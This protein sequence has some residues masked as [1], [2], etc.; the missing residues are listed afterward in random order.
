MRSLIQRALIFAVVLA[1]VFAVA[2]QIPSLPGFPSSSSS[3]GGGGSGGGSGSTNFWYDAGSGNIFAQEAIYN[4]DG[5]VN[6]RL[7]SGVGSN[8][9][10]NQP[11]TA[12][13]ISTSSYPTVGLGFASSGSGA[14]LQGIPYAFNPVDNQYAFAVVNSDT[15]YNAGGLLLWNQSNGGGFGQAP[16]GAAFVTGTA[17]NATYYGKLVA[18]GSSFGYATG[19][20][21]SVQPARNFGFR[22]DSSGTL[23]WTT[24]ANNGE[25]N[26]VGVTAGNDAIQLNNGA[27][28]HLGSGTNDYAF[29]DGTQWTWGGPPLL[30]SYATGSLPAS[31]N[32]S[33]AFDSTVGQPKYYSDGGWQS[34]GGSS[35][36]ANYWYD[37]GAGLITANESISYFASGSGPTDPIAKILL[38]QAGGSVASPSIEWRNQFDGRV[39]ELGRNAHR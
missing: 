8:F 13:A 12:V 24:E 31:S 5:G 23:W 1:S 30:P 3:S 28:L 35:G 17:G 18:G 10:A 4:P 21:V 37:G 25:F 11:A 6:I 29:S 19:I 2:Q 22:N 9:L 20:T 38:R 7:S 33:L 34:F 16:V 15:T 14:Q 39:A 32:G 36:S 27:R 26:F